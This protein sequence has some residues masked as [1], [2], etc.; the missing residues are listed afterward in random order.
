METPDRKPLGCEPQVEHRQIERSQALN[1]GDV[2]SLRREA[3]GHRI[4]ATTVRLGWLA[5]AAFV[6]G[7]VVLYQYGRR[8]FS[9]NL[10]SQRQVSQFLRSR[11][12]GD[13]PRP[14]LHHDL[15]PRGIIGFDRRHIFKIDQM[16]AVDSQEWC[17]P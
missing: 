10:R 5:R 4:S 16:R 9:P 8:A 6:C 3:A 11:S 15:H 17:A 2:L 14:T 12:A 13:N 1:V 7:C